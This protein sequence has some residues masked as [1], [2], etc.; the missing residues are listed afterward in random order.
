MHS[1]LIL[2]PFFAS[3]PSSPSPL[4]SSSS[5][6]SCWRLCSLHQLLWEI[7][8]LGSLVSFSASSLSFWA[9]WVALISAYLATTIPPPL[10]LPS[11]SVSLAADSPN[12]ASEQSLP[13]RERRPSV[14]APIVDIQGSVGPAGITRPKHRRTFTGFGAG[15]IR[16]VEGKLCF[17]SCLLADFSAAPP[18]WLGEGSKS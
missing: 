3:S 15:E 9:F 16:S 13:T 7:L 17:I 10:F 6:V 12:M 11:P 1:F 18:L 2:N 4:P 8:V 14:G 5:S